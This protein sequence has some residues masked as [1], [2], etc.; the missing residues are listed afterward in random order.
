MKF[1][2]IETKIVSV[3]DGNGSLH[4]I[5]DPRY[6][7]K[8]TVEREVSKEEELRDAMYDLRH[9]ISAVF[10]MHLLGQK[11]KA[12][13]EANSWMHKATVRFIEARKAFK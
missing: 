11:R 2:V 12:M 3:E 9:S 7:Y 13:R 6:T 5:F 4:T 10:N 1:K 8:V